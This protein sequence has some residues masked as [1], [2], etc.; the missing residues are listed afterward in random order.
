MSAPPRGPSRRRLPK[1]LPGENPPWRADRPRSKPREL[2]K[3]ILA[4]GVGPAGIDRR[5][6]PE[7][8]KAKNVVPRPDPLLP[9]PDP[10]LP[11]PAA[12]V[13]P[14]QSPRPLPPGASRPLPAALLSGRCPR[15]SSPARGP[16]FS[17]SFSPPL[18]RRRG[19]APHASRPASRRPFL[20]ACASTSSRLSLPI[21][22]LL[23]ESQSFPSPPLPWPR[24]IPSSRGVHVPSPIPAG[25][26]WAP[27]CPPP[28]R[29]HHL[30]GGGVR[31]AGH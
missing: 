23:P 4:A 16:V 29:R 28:A 20:L 18:A 22:L 19:R 14:V 6:E 3:K 25:R 13:G 21:I 1:H 17:L 5:N 2:I 7:E 15:R 10:L 30:C 31:G 8:E 9:R 11:R 12:G 27:G 24:E 26:L